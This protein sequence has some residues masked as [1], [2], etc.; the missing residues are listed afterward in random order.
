MLRLGLCVGR[1]MSKT[2]GKKMAKRAGTRFAAAIVALLLWGLGAAISRAD[3]LYVTNYLNDNIVK[4]N[5]GGVVSL[6]ASNPAHYPKGL[7]FDL[8]ANLY[9]VNSI[10][11]NIAKFSPSG[12]GSIFA[13]NPYVMTDLAFDKAGNLY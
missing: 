12:V 10:S 5:S 6:F 13:N 7:A 4:F 3:I 9:V 1:I 2:G 8:A 11:D